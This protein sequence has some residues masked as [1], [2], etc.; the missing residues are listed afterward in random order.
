MYIFTFLYGGVWNFHECHGPYFT[1]MFCKLYVYNWEK[2]SSLWSIR[3]PSQLSSSNCQQT[4][5][6]LD[7]RMYILRSATC[8]R[9][10]H[11]SWIQG[12]LQEYKFLHLS[13]GLET[14]WVASALYC[15]ILFQVS[16]FLH[17]FAFGLLSIF[18][19]RSDRKEHAS[20]IAE[21]F[22]P[23]QLRS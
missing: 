22:H 10:L 11:C 3:L 12:F 15:Y 2:L 1:F 17:P 16:L 4:A 19:I 5:I 9:L 23:C 20:V 18:P 7:R 14:T 13:A 8:R 21:A 6:T